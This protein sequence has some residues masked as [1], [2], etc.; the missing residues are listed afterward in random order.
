LGVQNS[1]SK[2]LHKAFA[3]WDK[4]EKMNNLVIANHGIIKKKSKVD[5]REIEKAKKIRSQYFNHEDS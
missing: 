3:F 2:S 1:Q 5:K 4:K